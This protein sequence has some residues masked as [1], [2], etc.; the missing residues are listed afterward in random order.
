MH[1]LKKGRRDGA[2]RLGTAA[3]KLFARVLRHTIDNLSYIQDNT[4]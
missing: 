1:I 3:P 2:E 4:L